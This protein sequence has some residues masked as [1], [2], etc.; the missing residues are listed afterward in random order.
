[1]NRRAAITTLTGTLI[2]NTYAQRLSAAEAKAELPMEWM[3]RASIPVLDRCIEDAKFLKE[4]SDLQDKLLGKR[5]KEVAYRRAVME[6]K[7]LQ[8]SPLIRAKM[9]DM[10]GLPAE[11]RAKYDEL[12][13]MTFDPIKEL[14]S[15]K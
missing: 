8:G 13:R 11:P 1:M 6:S 12:G 10:M 15:P 5:H 4:F 3:I 14:R 2:A 7:A 9:R